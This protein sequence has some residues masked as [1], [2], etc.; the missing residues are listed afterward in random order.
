MARG[1]NSRYDEYAIY[2]GDEYQFSGSLE[3]CAERLGVKPTSVRFY[4]SQAYMRRLDKRNTDNP[5]I[6]VNIGKWED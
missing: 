4:A 2:K 5:I 6:A 3:Y 1:R